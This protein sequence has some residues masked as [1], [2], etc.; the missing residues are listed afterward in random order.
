MSGNGCAL[1]IIYNLLIYNVL[2]IGLVT[3]FFGG[4]YSFKSRSISSIEG[5]ED[6]MSFGKALPSS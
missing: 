6:R 4:S 5:S 2:F 3:I 1:Q